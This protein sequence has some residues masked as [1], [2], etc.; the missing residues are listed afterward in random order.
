MQARAAGGGFVFCWFHGSVAAPGHCLGVKNNN[1]LE[2]T[3]SELLTAPRL[4][5]LRAQRGKRS[6][7][8]DGINK[9]IM[10]ADIS[11]E[12]RREQKLGTKAR[13]KSLW[14]S[15]E[16]QLED[17]GLNSKCQ[18]QAPFFWRGMLKLGPSLKGGA[19]ICSPR[20]ESYAENRV[21]CEMKMNCKERNQWRVEEMEVVRRQGKQEVGCNWFVNRQDIFSSEFRPSLPPLSNLPSLKWSEIM[22]FLPRWPL[23][24]FL[25]LLWYLVMREPFKRKKKTIIRSDATKHGSNSRHSQAQGY[26]SPLL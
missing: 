5:N 6:D 22:Q 9:D 4:P 24:S 10:F 15:L 14:S 8:P 3:P 19:W 7:H 2:E 20:E 21:P 17:T 26:W 16:L 1:T 25:P 23:G 13:N 12:Q 18:I 11:R